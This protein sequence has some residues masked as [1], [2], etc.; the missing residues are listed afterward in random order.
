M[1][2]KI[3]IN[4]LPIQATQLSSLSS[5]LVQS[6]LYSVVV[7]TQNIYSVILQ[8]SRIQKDDI[9]QVLHIIVPII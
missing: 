7:Q 4:M 1:Q 9:F 3:N 5:H 6:I 8:R 2:V